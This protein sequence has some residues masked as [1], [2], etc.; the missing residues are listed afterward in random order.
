MPLSPPFLAPPLTRAH[1]CPPLRPPSHHAA[2]PFQ[3][4]APKSFSL[5]VSSHRPQEL[6]PLQDLINKF[7]Q[8]R[9]GRAEGGSA[10]AAQG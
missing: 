8:A 10:P 6:V 3:K 7:L 5:L 4:P 1:A 9:R 2:A